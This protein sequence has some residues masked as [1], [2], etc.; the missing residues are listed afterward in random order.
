MEMHCFV[1]T[2]IFLLLSFGKKRLWQNHFINAQSFVSSSFG[3][4]C[5]LA[6]NK[7]VVFLNLHDVET[8]CLSVLSVVFAYTFGGFH[9]L[10]CFSVQDLRNTA[11][12]QNATFLCLNTKKSENV[13][14]DDLDL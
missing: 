5:I 9:F 6:T 3:K 4:K 10:R 2:Q 14:H 8:Q 7:L 1:H 13:I 11:W 12:R